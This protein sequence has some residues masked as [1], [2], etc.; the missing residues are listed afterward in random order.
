MR[1]FFAFRAKK[2]LQTGVRTGC[3]YLI[4]LSV[5][6]DIRRFYWLRELYEADFHKPGI[7]GSGWVWANAWDVFRRAQSRVGRGRWAD[8]GFVVCFGWADFFVCSFFSTSF[9]FFERTRPA[10][11]MRPPLASFTSLLVLSCHDSSRTSYEHSFEYFCLQTAEDF[12]AAL[13]SHTT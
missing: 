8:V 5:S 4:S 6:C 12:S 11:S 2:P 10:A 7:Y 9:F 3:H 1:P 13:A